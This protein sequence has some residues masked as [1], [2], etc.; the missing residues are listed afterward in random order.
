MVN[1]NIQSKHLALHNHPDLK[2]TERSICHT[3]SAD[4]VKMANGS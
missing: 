1:N 4:D 2:E 3:T